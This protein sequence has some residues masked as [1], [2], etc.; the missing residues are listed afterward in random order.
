M[1]ALKIS[2]TSNLRTVTLILNK[3]AHLL[4]SNPEKLD[5]D[6][7]KHQLDIVDEKD[8]SFRIS[9]NEISSLLGDGIHV[10]EEQV[11]LDHFEEQVQK[12]ASIES[13]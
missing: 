7:L 5:L 11:T 4:K 10:D 2:R 6:R 12:T 8:T 13:N 9:H 3:H 1:E